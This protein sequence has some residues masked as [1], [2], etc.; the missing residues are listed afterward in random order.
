[1]KK[2]VTV[3]VALIVMVM[4]VATVG[5]QGDTELEPYTWEATGFTISVPVEWEGDIIEEESSL[6]ILSAP[7]TE[8]FEG[9]GLLIFYFPPE[10][11]TALATPAEGDTDFDIASV[12]ASQLVEGLAAE[13]DSTELEEL[14][15]DSG[16]WP[17]YAFEDAESVQFYTVVLGEDNAFLVSLGSSNLDTAEE[18]EALFVEIVNSIEIE[19]AD[20]DTTDTDDTDTD[21]DTE[22]ESELDD[23][24]TDTET[25][26]INLEFSGE[27]TE[28]ST[29]VPF[30][31]EAEE[32]DIVTITMIADEET[33]LDTLLTLLDPNG[34]TVTTNDDADSASLGLNSQIINQF[35]PV[36]GE[37]TVLA[38][39]YGGE[40]SF[41]LTIEEN[42]LEATEIAYGDTID[43]EITEDAES[44]LYSFEG[45]A[46]DAVTISM[47][48]TTEISGLDTL[49]LLRDAVGNELTR[50][51]DS[52]EGLNS[53]IE[54]VLPED[55]TYI[56][57][58]TRYGG[59]GSYTLSLNT[60]E[61]TAPAGDDDP[62]GDDVE[63]E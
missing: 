46:G 54:F 49:L 29:S 34:D 13:G 14:E 31:F 62:A 44:E 41:V 18:L 40:G 51:D 5:A 63:M 2:L 15:T 47:T 36:T 20:A 37:Y 59:E 56:I 38:G 60:G 8:D 19:G 57:V 23:P 26:G 30:T 24:E 22:S 16:V 28:S 52:G 33:S 61:N 1:M 25:S 7:E 27:I 10:Q 48:S 55:G 58:A 32:G 21:P 6:A 43:S 50:N 53:R 11:V 39:R 42:D 17:F 4:S 35:L 3:L 45:S 9:E 12:I